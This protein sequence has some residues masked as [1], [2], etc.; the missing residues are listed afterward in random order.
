VG[1]KIGPNPTD[2]AKSGTKR[3]LLTD[4]VGVPIGLCVAAANTVD[5]KLVAKTIESIPLVRPVEADPFAIE[6]L[7][8]DA[9]YDKDLVRELGDLFGYTLH[10]VPRNKEARELKK[11]LG[12]QARR[13]VVERSHSWF[14]RYRAI[15]IRWEKKVAN[16]L[17]MLHLTCAIISFR[18]AGLLR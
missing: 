18:A 17:A 1:K 6:H 2:R 8:L 9:G 3:S 10:I 11:Q 4:G 15:L 14:N 12:K 5:F 7:C 16:Y 13:W